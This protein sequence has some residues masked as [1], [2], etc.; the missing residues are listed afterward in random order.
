MTLLFKTSPSY[1][2]SFFAF[3]I[4]LFYSNASFCQE[5]FTLIVHTGS[6]SKAGTNANVSVGLG[7][8]GEYI[9]NP[10]INHDAF[11]C[12]MVD[13]VM[14]PA[15]CNSD[16]V[17]YIWVGHDDK[18][19]GSDW[20]LDKIEVISPNG[21]RKTFVCDC[22]LEEDKADNGWKKLGEEKKP[23]S[24]FVR[25]FD[26][27]TVYIK[28][29]IGEDN[30]LDVQWGNSADGTPL[31]LWKANAGKAQ[32]FVIE[33]AFDEMFYIKSGLGGDKYLQVENCSRQAEV[34][35]ILGPKSSRHKGLWRFEKLINNNK[36]FIQSQFGTYLDVQWGSDKS[37]TPI[38]LWPKNNGL[39]Q[40]WV[41]SESQ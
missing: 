8:Q 26:N 3:S 28:S 29:L 25:K 20:F 19:P 10:R 32:Q 24:E 11:E 4:F 12:G 5:Q 22:W 23:D 21:R 30:Y 41:I 34:R 37:G 40:Q 35:V 38:W 9:L 33:H 31:H 1:L 6:Q 36:Y 2:F 15:D 7:N 27:K 16:I 39:A 17:N 18:Y 14:I 13:T